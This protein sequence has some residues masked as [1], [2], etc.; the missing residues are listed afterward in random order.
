MNTTHVTSTLPPTV[1]RLAQ[2]RAEVILAARDLNAAQVEQLELTQALEAARAAYHA[3]PD[4]LKPMRAG[5]L[6]SVSRILTEHA[7]TVREAQA[8]H[9]QA[10]AALHAAGLT[11]QLDALTGMVTTAGAELIGALARIAPDLARLAALHRDLRDALRAIPALR[12]QLH[13]IQ[14]HAL[15]DVG[16]DDGLTLCTLPELIEDTLAHALSA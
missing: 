14:P 1:E 16:L 9:A 2:L 6:A 12:A 10:E 5:E 7:Q 15:P 4:D 13:A 11:D 8:Q 3:A